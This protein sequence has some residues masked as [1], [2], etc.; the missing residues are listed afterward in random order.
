[1]LKGAGLD[2]LWHQAAA[3]VV[4]TIIMLALAVRNFKLKLA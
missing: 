1:M 2:T 4:L 3:L